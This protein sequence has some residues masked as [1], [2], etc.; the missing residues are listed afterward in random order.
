MD[1]LNKRRRMSKEGHPQ[2]MFNRPGMPAV[3]LPNS[4]FGASPQLNSPAT[5]KRPMQQSP[6][7]SGSAM[8]NHSAARISSPNTSAAGYNQGMASLNPQD[9]FGGRPGQG[10]KPNPQPGM[11]R[12]TSNDGRDQRGGQAATGFRPGGGQQPQQQQPQQQQQQQFNYADQ[13]YLAVDYSS[14]AQGGMYRPM[15]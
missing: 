15:R 12:Q 6:H 2:P 3:Q 14:G 1:P 5:F 13:N 9:Y 7:L 4:P 10:F 11:A 8:M